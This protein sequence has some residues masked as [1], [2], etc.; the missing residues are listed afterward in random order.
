MSWELVFFAVFSAAMLLCG[1][2]VVAFENPV[3][4]A[5]A[6]VGS[7]IN[8]A[9]LFVMLGAEFLGVLQII[10]YTGAVLVLVLF[11][12]MLIDPTKLPEFYVGAPLQRFAS[13][14]VGA[15]LL[16]EIGVAIITRTALEQIGPHT[17][18]MVQQM[19][20][21][22]QAI[23]QVMLSEY[24]LAFEIASLVLTVGVVGAVVIGLPNRMVEPNTVT[25][26]LGHTRGSSDMLAA[27]PKFESPMNIP[28]ERYTAP[29][30]ERTVVM[31]KDPDA[32]THPGETSK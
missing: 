19:G 25:M 27:G 16:A 18:A 23:G 1:L 9:A 11:T 8:V 31:T 28:A 15:I 2:G 21:N 5:V 20:G 32:Y 24:A 7:F 6:L 13:V 30:G 12:I 26:S 3:H 22:V 10:V 4:S 29:V 17:E 14:V